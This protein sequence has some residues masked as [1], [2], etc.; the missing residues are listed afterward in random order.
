MLIEGFDQAAAMEAATR[1]RCRSLGLV[2]IDH[3]TYTATPSSD[4]HRA[5]YL[6]DPSVPARCATC[7]LVLEWHGS[8]SEGST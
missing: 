6:V 7:A 5:A 3:D 2:E 8:L 4:K 1:P